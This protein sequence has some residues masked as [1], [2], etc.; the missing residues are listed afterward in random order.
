M[1][2]RIHEG[3]RVLVLVDK[4]R[5]FVIKVERGKI[6]GTDK[7]YISHDNIIG[8]LYGSSVETSMG[9]KALLLKPLRHDYIAGFKR[10]T[11]IIHPKDAALMIYISGIG[12]GSRVGEAGVGTGSLTVAIASLIGD[13]GIL[14][15]YDILE[16]ALECTR[17]NLEKAGLL[18]R[19]VL[20]KQDVK[21]DIKVEPLDAFFLDIPDPWNAVLSVGRVLKPS[22]PILIYVPTV[23]QVE[24]TVLSLRSSGLFGDIHVYEILLRELQVEPES[25]RPFSHMIGHT[26]YIIFARKLLEMPTLNI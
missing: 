3:D 22:A 25:V 1:N 11:Q 18:H 15:G 4:K 20:Q 13:N 14:Y 2:E 17:Q 24:K 26:G 6:L 12:P 19:V 9:V 10:I 5:K 8:L 7:G 23:N 21:T 16:E